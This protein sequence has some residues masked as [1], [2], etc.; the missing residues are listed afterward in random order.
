VNKPKIILLAHYEPDGRLSEDWCRLLR[1]LRAGGFADVVLVSTGLDAERYREAL[2]GTRTIIRENVGYDFYSWRRAIA[3]TSLSDYR[4]A[5][6]INNSFHIVDPERFCEVLQAPLPG[7]VDVRGLTASWEIAYHAQ[8]Y[9]MQF[10]N[11]AVRSAPFESFWAN[12]EPVSDRTSVIGRYEIGLSREL[13]R[14]FRID[15]IF[16]PGPYEKYLLLRR[17]LKNS[18]WVNG[19]T[20]ERGYEAAKGVLNP[21][22]M[23]WDCLL[24]RY[25]IVKKQL[26]HQNPLNWPIENIVGFV[27]ACMGAERSGE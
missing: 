9:F 25:G 7:D 16:R 1:L 4:E 19:A 5:I 22:L 23:L 15:S 21:A 6:L 18:S 12:L 24:P 13:S 26:V 20:L 17:G 27:A 2:E 8:S 3:E 14:H 10:S 11:A